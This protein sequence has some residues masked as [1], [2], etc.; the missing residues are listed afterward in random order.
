[1]LFLQEGRKKL[2]FNTFFKAIIKG[3]QY[4]DQMMSNW[5][6]DYLAGR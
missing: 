1:M 3:F 6:S 5:D 4:Q 2:I